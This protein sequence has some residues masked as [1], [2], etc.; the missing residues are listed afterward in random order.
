MTS[1]QSKSMADS[2]TIE[3]LNIG[4]NLLQKNNFHEAA[5]EYKKVLQIDPN[6]SI[7]WSNLGS[8]QRAMGNLNAALVCAQRAL[9]IA[10]NHPP[11]L[12]N[13]GNI[14]T[15]FDHREDALAAHAKSY[16]YN[17]HDFLIHK[18]YATSL[19]EFC[20][21]EHALAHYK[22]ASDLQPEN[23]HI[24]WDMAITYLHMGQYAEGWKAFEAR[25]KIGK[26]EDRPQVAPKWNGEDLHKK[27]ILI[28]GEQGF[29]DTI[30]CSRY[31]SLVKEKGA[32]VIFECKKELH[33]LFSTISDIDNMTEYG[34]A[35]EPF[36]YQ[37][38]IMSLPGVF[39][40]HLHNIPEPPQLMT[41]KKL[42][43]NAEKLLAAAGDKLK[44]GIVW[45]GSVT[46]K[47]NRKRAVSIDRFL[48]LASIPG[49]Q[50]YSLQKGPCEK[51]LYESGADTFIWD[52]SG[53][54]NDFTDTAAIL[55]DLDLVIM[56]DS[57]VA[58]LAGSIGCPI[59][60]LLNF[61]P[62]W[63]Y[64]NHRE[65]CPWYPSMRL[66]RQNIPGDWDS[67]FERVAVELEKAVIMKKTGL[68]HKQKSNNKGP[69]I[70]DAS[71]L[72]A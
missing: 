53:D 43:E 7:A 17:P 12:T 20:Q 60:N 31:I 33:S 19:R 26:M 71:D 37:I 23:E 10:P 67:V 56:T 3:H 64:L 47:D 59:W 54:L 49:I 70:K 15:D 34:K 50:L 58:H 68:W 2:A 36:D 11:Y 51:D 35:D 48:P 62:Y 55:K 13:Y 24:K 8:A 6:N 45:S 22:A 61:K 39:N 42:P 40:T 30:L 16:H 63:L 41:S 46:F 65:D 9:S 4:T 1:N 69:Y 57:S 44:I 32:R 14:L 29:G 25:W 52:L 27:T 38:S 28:H 66:I 18:N 72:A 5:A 21:F